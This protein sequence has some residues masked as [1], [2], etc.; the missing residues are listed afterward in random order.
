MDKHPETI[1][2]ESTVPW[3]PLGQIDPSKLPEP[4]E[5]YP[6]PWEENH[7][8]NGHLDLVDGLGRCFAHVYC[9]DYHEWS[10]LR[11]KLRA[12][13]DW[14]LKNKKPMSKNAAI[15]EMKRHLD[16]RANQVE[17][18][19]RSFEEWLSLLDVKS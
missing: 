14:A 12:A 17:D 19:R 7:R 8:G 3:E 1:E 2:G 10:V 15:C 18:G 6:G 9:W 13:M 16:A 11:S 5:K 4:S